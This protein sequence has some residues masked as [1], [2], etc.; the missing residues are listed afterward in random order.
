MS[1]DKSR[2]NAPGQLPT[3][4]ELW[5]DCCPFFHDKKL[6][7]VDS[8]RPR[9]YALSYINTLHSGF[10]LEHRHTVDITGI[11][12]LLKERTDRPENEIFSRVYHRIGRAPNR[13]RVLGSVLL[14]EVLAGHGPS[15]CCKDDQE[16]DPVAHVGLSEGSKR[17][18]T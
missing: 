13:L 15:C 9:R 6:C 4:P 18:H 5:V 11:R 12:P 10:G 3:N 8:L 7:Q 2:R 1:R 17:K 14:K 16:T